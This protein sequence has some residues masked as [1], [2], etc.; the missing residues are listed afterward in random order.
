MAPVLQGLLSRPHG[1]TSTTSSRGSLP[2]LPQMLLQRE[3]SLPLAYHWNTSANTPRCQRRAGPRSHY[4]STCKK[5]AAP[6][7]SCRA[8]AATLLIPAFSFPQ[9]QDSREPSDSMEKLTPYQSSRVEVRLV[10]PSP[11]HGCWQRKPR[12]SHARST[13]PPRSAAA[14]DAS[15]VAQRRAREE[16]SEGT[17]TPAPSWLRCSRFASERDAGGH[18]MKK[19]AGGG[20]DDG[21][22]GR[23]ELGKD[24]AQRWRDETAMLLLS[25]DRARHRAC[26]TPRRSCARSWL[27]PMSTRRAHDVAAPRPTTAGLASSPGRVD[28]PRPTRCPRQ[29]LA[30]SVPGPDLTL[31]AR[32]LGGHVTSEEAPWWMVSLSPCVRNRAPVRAE[33]VVRPRLCH[34]VHQQHQSLALPDLAFSLRACMHT[35]TTT[36]VQ[37]PAGFARVRLRRYAYYSAPVHLPRRAPTPVCAPRSS[38]RSRL[39]ACRHSQDS[40]GYARGGT[41]TRGAIDRTPLSALS[42]GGRQS[43]RDVQRQ[44][45]AAVRESPALPVCAQG[46]SP[47]PHARSSGVHP[48]HSRLRSSCARARESDHT[49]ALLHTCAAAHQRH[50]DSTLEAPMPRRTRSPTRVQSTAMEAL[51]CRRAR[52]AGSPSSE[53]ARAVL[54]SPATAHQRCGAAPQRLRL[55]RERFVIGAWISMRGSLASARALACHNHPRARWLRS[56]GVPAAPRRPAP[57]SHA[58]GRQRSLLPAL[59]SGGRHFQR[60]VASN[61]LD[62]CFA[63][64]RERPALP[65]CAQGYSPPRCALA[66]RYTGTAPRSLAYASRRLATLVLLRSLHRPVQCKHLVQRPRLRLLTPSPRPAAVAVR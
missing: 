49:P 21:I 5:H 60:V 12:G 44:H 17:R 32:V 52:G 48:G 10:L 55:A 28:V 36:R 37:V 38:R 29:Q 24:G 34:I 63:P 8:L 33:L 46:H 66:S 6:L 64:I 47:P 39:R 57:E 13:P 2:E 1:S 54:R 27:A 30:A 19:D 23:R 41:A 62:E 31:H 3:P 53:A 40:P 11:H 4:Y 26:E 22:E 18:G 25:A 16:G 15:P 51:R 35:R 58:M 50:A 43:Q 42:S 61:G 7:K 56:R 14:L 65:V 45:L 9:E 59:P 20:G